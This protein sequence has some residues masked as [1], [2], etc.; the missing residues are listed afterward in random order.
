MLIDTRSRGYGERQ[1]L[2]RE[3]KTVHCIADSQDTSIGGITESQIYWE[4]TAVQRIPDPGQKRKK[5]CRLATVSSRS[6]WGK[7]IYQIARL[8][9]DVPHRQCF[10]RYRNHDC[11]AERHERDLIA[12]FDYS[13]SF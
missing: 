3:M 13:D 5:P 4:H 7:G 6:I 10:M 9:L 12:I 1:T 2:K 11:V 8:Q